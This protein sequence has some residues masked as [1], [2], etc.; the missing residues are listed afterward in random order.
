M[1]LMGAQ[2]FRFL[3]VGGANTI[4]TYVIYLTLLNYI[5]YRLAFS[6]A[7]VAG[8]LIAYVLNSR[9]VFKAA[10]SSR[11]MLQYPFVYVLQYLGCLLL[12]GFL[13]DYMG[14]DERIAPLV[15]VVLLALP[16]F[17]LNRWVLLRRTAQ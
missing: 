5:G 10:L 14:I 12:L 4:A 9:F 15:N 16:T 6:T 2:V 3:L 1:G 17:F 7:F 13:V 8:I 11:S